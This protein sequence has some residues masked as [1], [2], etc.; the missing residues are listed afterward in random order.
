MDSANHNSK[1]KVKGKFLHPLERVRARRPPKLTNRTFVCI[2]EN[3]AVGKETAG[4]SNMIK[5]LVK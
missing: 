5:N 3:R 1:G 2:V 4:N